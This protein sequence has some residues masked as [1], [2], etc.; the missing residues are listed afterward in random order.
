VINDLGEIAFGADL[1][2]GTVATFLATPVAPALRASRPSAKSAEKRLS[3]SR[4]RM[5]ML[6]ARH[7]KPLMHE[8]RGGRGQVHR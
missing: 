6:K 5:A 3:I 7:P 4:E 1:S 2:D 8:I